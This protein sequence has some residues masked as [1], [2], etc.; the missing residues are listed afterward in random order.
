MFVQQNGKQNNQSTRTERK[1]TQHNTF[2]WFGLGGFLFFAK[3]NKKDHVNPVRKMSLQII[4]IKRIHIYTLSSIYVT[5][6][7]TID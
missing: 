6:Q 2:D 7:L 5:K 4:L 1:N 3:R